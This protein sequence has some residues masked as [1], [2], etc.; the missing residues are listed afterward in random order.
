MLPPAPDKA[1]ALPYFLLKI[2]AG[3]LNAAR[4]LGRLWIGQ[5]QGESV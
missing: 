1:S 2:G 5:N 3:F 4:D